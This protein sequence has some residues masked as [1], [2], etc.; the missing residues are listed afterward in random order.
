MINRDDKFAAN[1]VCACGKIFSFEGGDLFWTSFHDIKFKGNHFGQKTLIFP[2]SFMQ[3][4]WLLSIQSPG[5]PYMAQ[6]KGPEIQKNMLII[7]KFEIIAG[8]MENVNVTV[9]R[10]LQN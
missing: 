10:G 4:H 9:S 2:L 3:I 8:I 1:W 6:S 7:M 5:Q